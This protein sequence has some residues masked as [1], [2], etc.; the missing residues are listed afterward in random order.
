MNLM[1]GG[2]LAAGASLG[3]ARARAAR[4]TG[5]R[6]RSTHQRKLSTLDAALREVLALGGGGDVS[7]ALDALWAAARA[8]GACACAWLAPCLGSALTLDEV[9]LTARYPEA[10]R[11]RLGDCTALR[12]A[13]ASALPVPASTEST[14]RHPVESDL[15]AAGIRALY[16]VP[17]RAG[18]SVEGFLIFAACKGFTTAD[19]SALELLAGGFSLAARSRRLQQELR[20]HHRVLEQVCDGC[21]A[22]LV[23]L[24]S[25]GRLCSCSETCRQ[26]LGVGQEQV[27]GRL[28]GEV[29]ASAESGDVED[30][31]AEAIAGG[32]GVVVRAH[33]TTTTGEVA[34]E[35]HFSQPR[36][37][38][39]GGVALVGVGLNLTASLRL[40]SELAKAERL[41]LV[42]Q[43]VAEVAHELNNPLTAILGFSEALYAKAGL[44]PMRQNLERVVHQAHRCRS[45]VRNLLSVVR[46]HAPGREAVSLN[47]L[48]SQA[49]SLL[50][51]Q[52]QVGGIRLVTT[53]E[54][55]LPPVLADRHQI[56]QVLMNLL[57]NG[58][59]ALR[60]AGGGAITVRTCSEGRRVCLAVEDDGPGVPEELIPRIFEPFV[61]TKPEGSGTGLG[62]SV[63][64]GIVQQHGGTISV[65]NGPEGGA[66]FT[67]ELPAVAAEREPAAGATSPLTRSGQDMTAFHGARV[68]VVDDEDAL[69]WLISE[70]L[71]A[72]G[73]VV[74]DTSDPHRA[75]ELVAERDFDLVISDLRMPG[76]SGE[77]FYARLGEIRS[78]LARRVIFV[79]GD[80]ASDSA[81]RFLSQANVPTLEK[82][83]AIQELADRVAEF[84]AAHACPA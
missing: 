43:L 76:L 58:F 6:G 62:L 55:D 34:V 37:Q 9:R 24:D 77:E 61:T 59:Q 30:S 45:I 49:A 8:Q 52:F 50:H 42:G 32:F 63:S 60:V 80:V 35:W 38:E 7:R 84:L 65:A 13:R 31:I 21:G 47:E 3:V 72:E 17:L 51:Y 79:T 82:P 66:V 4:G 19:L 78:D 16:A 14:S 67:L 33:H 53:L 25:R 1:W 11:W 15:Q 36:T 12:A 64:R 39:E 70:V 5:R 41:A 73:L 81:H 48:V 26:T 2:L 69:R 18:E 28:W 46:Q 27:W 57:T 71:T 83:F 56:Q 29:F 40:E 68:L 22:L 74:E 54:P 10:L 20:D 44:G 75:L 23:E